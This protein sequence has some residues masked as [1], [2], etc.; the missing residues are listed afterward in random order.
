MTN[1]IPEIII[2]TINPF[3]GKLTSAEK[4]KKKFFRKFYSYRTLVFMLERKIFKYR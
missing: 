4:K 3:N 2:F 1:L